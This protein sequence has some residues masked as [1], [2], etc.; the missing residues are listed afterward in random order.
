MSKT[1]LYFQGQVMHWKVDADGNFGLCLYF[2]EDENETDLDKMRPV[3]PKFS[4]RSIS[5][6]SLKIFSSDL[7]TVYRIYER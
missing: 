3:F 2:T 6:L 7:H 4:V 1:Y 5:S